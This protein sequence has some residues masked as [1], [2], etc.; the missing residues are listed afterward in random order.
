MLQAFLVFVNR[1]RRLSLFF[2]QTSVLE[3]CEQTFRSHSIKILVFVVTSR[4]DK[5]RESYRCVRKKVLTTFHGNVIRLFNR[6]TNQFI[7]IV[8]STFLRI[9][10]VRLPHFVSVLWIQFVF[11]FLN[12]SWEIH[13]KPLGLSFT[14]PAKSFV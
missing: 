4:N 6:L 10:F 2:S 7:I 1:R 9:L 8:K 3:N 12:R 14:N 5:V 13:V 11:H